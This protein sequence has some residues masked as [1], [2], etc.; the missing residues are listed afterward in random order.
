MWL[1]QSNYIHVW[2]SYSETHYF[3]QLIYAINK[4]SK[5]KKYKKG[6][7]ETSMHVTEWKELT[8]KVCT[9]H[10]C[11]YSIYL[12]KATLLRWEKDQC[13][14]GLREEGQIGIVQKSW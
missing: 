6:V 9:L 4:I 8:G 7:V 14:P 2:K 3:V 12:E 5:R 11:N 1:Y 10:D 13:L